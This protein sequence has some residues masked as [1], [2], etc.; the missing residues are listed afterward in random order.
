[1][2]DRPFDLLEGPVLSVLLKPAGRWVILR[3][4]NLIAPAGGTSR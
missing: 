4:A 1:M 2:T 3:D